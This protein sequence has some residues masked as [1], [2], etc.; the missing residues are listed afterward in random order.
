MRARSVVLPAVVLA[1]F[2]VA[3]PALAAPKGGRLVPF[4]SCP[5]LLSYAK[6]HAAPYVTAS[7]IGQ[8]APV[9]H[10]VA[11]GVA[12]PNAIAA[13][14]AAAAS[15]PQEGI[16]YSG[17]NDQE[18]GVDEPDTVKT[19]GNTLYAIEGN[20]LAAVDISGKAPKLLDT[21]P[22]QAGSSAEL[23]LSGT[24]LLVLSRGGYFFEPLPAQPAELIAPV[25]SSSI[26]TEVDVSD[27]SALKVV[28]T[29][30]LDGEYVDARMVGSVVRV[31]SSSSLPYAIPFAA[32]SAAANKA[33]LAHSRIS[34]WL[35][36]YTLGSGAPH[37]VV[38]CRNVLRPTAYSGLGMLTVLTI[39]LAQGLTPVDSTGVMTDGRIV[40]ASPTNLY[41]ATERW[42]TRPLVV[43]PEQ[44]VPG[45]TT[46]IN[47]FDIS[48]PTKTTYLGSGT[49]PGYLLDQWS[50]SD[51]QG[52]LRVVSTDS[53]AWWGP[54]PATQSYLT[55][56]EAQGGSLVQVGQLTGLGPGER[57]NAVRFAGNT[58]YV[59][60]FRQID[61]LY[62]IDVSN[63]AKP[64]EL[65][66]LTIEG[67]S[68]YLHP[69]GNGLLL[70]VGQDVPTATQTEPG[71]S[72]L[73]LFDVSDLSHPTLLAHVSLG[74]GWSAAETD[75]HA[76]LYW[77]ATSLVVVPLNGTAFAYRVS[78]S[79][80]QQ[81]GTVA[82]PNGS[83]DRSLVDRTALVTVSSAG[84]QENSLDTLADLGWV[85]FPAQTVQPP[86]PIGGPVPIAN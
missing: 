19:D 28:Q 33:T 1:A 71:G 83:I 7:G 49:V 57:V 52:V 41:V 45:V 60:T 74:P 62:T 17:T 72:Q 66:S 25:A 15:T 36:T 39:D 35:P 3:A 14:S 29:L 81:L 79:G 53:P 11:P 16:D 48:D 65:G 44:P 61:P 67:Y 73:S 55:T 22:L 27:P 40:Y 9:A 24:H 8:V 13:P 18:A 76:F 63:P 75:H 43:T 21:M 64:Q 80:F 50:M 47:D 30:T 54:G 84:V 20:S 68:S 78:R 69:L 34:A 26:L 4:Q 42:S 59:D 58:A 82:Q 31:V 56:L 6:A 2:A 85:S 38:Q 5:A 12:T 51:F 37:P 23:L 86:I 10:A 70:G 46:Q 32:G 77:P